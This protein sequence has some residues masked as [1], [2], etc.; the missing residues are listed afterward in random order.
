[1]IDLNEMLNYLIRNLL[2]IEENFDDF[3][4]NPALYV[5][6]VSSSSDSHY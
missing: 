4:L 2:T 5:S 3:C 1:M 6:V